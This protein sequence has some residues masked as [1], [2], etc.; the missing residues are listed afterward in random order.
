KGEVAWSPIHTIT[1]AWNGITDWFG[2]LWGGVKNKAGAAWD[3]MKEKLS[4]SPLDVIAGAWGGISGW[5]GNMWDGITASAAAAMDWITGKLE[6]VG[7][8]FSKVKGWLSFGGDDEEG[9]PAQP[10]GSNAQALDLGSSQQEAVAR[11]QEALQRGPARPQLSGG[12]ASQSP[13]ERVRE[14]TQTITNHVQLH[15][16]RS[17]GEED[18]TYAQRIA[19]MVM[20]ELNQRQQGALYDG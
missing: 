1:S 7:N 9:A 13:A 10:G 20:D 15:V 2:G 5:F 16:T 12:E 19:E 4:W 8:A 18:Q 6:W 14:V 17:E 3:W 11:G